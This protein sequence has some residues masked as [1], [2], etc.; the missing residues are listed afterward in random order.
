M[1]KKTSG[2]FNSIDVIEMPHKY[3]IAYIFYGLF[4]TGGVSL[5]TAGSP[6]IT[7]SPESRVAHSAAGLEDLG[8]FMCCH[9]LGD[10]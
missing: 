1:L 7:G 5:Y 2:I 9:L 10:A 8:L 6:Y 3:W 4:C